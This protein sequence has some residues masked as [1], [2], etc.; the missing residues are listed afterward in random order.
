MIYESYK[1]TRKNTATELNTQIAEDESK[2]YIDSELG[3]PYVMHSGKNARS[4]SFATVQDPAQDNQ[5]KHAIKIKS[6]KKTPVK[7]G[8]ETKTKKV[9]VLSATKT[10]PASAKLKK[11]GPGHTSMNK[12]DVV[13]L[14]KPI[15]KNK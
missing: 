7:E 8:S 3:S 15:K 13:T 12:I 6:K 5:Q 9:K 10:G 1:D 4:V 14:L 11:S 2:E